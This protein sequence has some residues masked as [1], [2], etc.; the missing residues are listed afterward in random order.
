MTEIMPRA[1]H[2]VGVELV[3]Q[4]LKTYEWKGHSTLF[5]FS[6]YLKISEDSLRI[7]LRELLAAGEVEKISIGKD[8]GRPIYIYKLLDEQTT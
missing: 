4:A 5:Y 1:K 2:G 8:Y 6:Q 7:C 3:R